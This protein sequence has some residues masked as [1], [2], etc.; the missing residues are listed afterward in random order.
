MTAV[1]NALAQLAYFEHFKARLARTCI[2]TTY[3]KDSSVMGWLNDVKWMILDDIESGQNTFSVDSLG[4]ICYCTEYTSE[5]GNKHAVQVNLVP[6]FKP[7]T[8]VNK[9]KYNKHITFYFNVHML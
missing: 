6:R 7:N 8:L 2:I 5:T 3:H 1:D 9:N 4:S